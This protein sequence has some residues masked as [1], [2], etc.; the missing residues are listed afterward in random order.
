MEVKTIYFERPGPQNTDKTLKAA[1]KRAQELG[2]KHVVVA[3]TSG[4]TGVKAAEIFQG[5]GIEVIVVAHQYGFLQPGKI[6]LKKQLEE[7]IKSLGAKLLIGTDIFTMVP[8][9]FRGKLGG[10]P[11]DVVSATLRM[12]CQG[13][14]VCVEIAVMAAD[15]GLIPVD[16]DIIAI[17]G[18]GSGAD[19]TIVLKP[20]D[21]SRMFTDLKIREIIAKPR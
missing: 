21:I 8:R 7:K 2:I 19:T 4:E 14:K 1:K 18:T 6:E 12:F 5:T 11:L 13:V 15:A 17:A 10:N 16:Q 3:T 20:A 9:A